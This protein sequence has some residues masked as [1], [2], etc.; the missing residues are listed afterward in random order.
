MFQLFAHVLWRSS[1]HVTCWRRLGL[2]G[3]GLFLKE[4][5]VS[6]PPVTNVPSFCHI[7]VGFC[8][9]AGFVCRGLQFRIL[10]MKKRSNR[11]N[12][13]GEKEQNA[14][15]SVINSFDGDFNTLHVNGTSALRDWHFAKTQQ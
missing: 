12:K 2:T 8:K 4:V 9:K 3:D 11:K 15:L 14:S 7:T 6:E 10:L 13:C 1:V 5:D